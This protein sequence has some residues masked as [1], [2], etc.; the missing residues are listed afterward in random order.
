MTKASPTYSKRQKIWIALAA[1]LYPLLHYYNSNFDIADSPIQWA[2]LLGICIVFPLVSVFVFPLLLKWKPNAFLQKRYLACINLVVFFGLVAMLVFMPNDKTLAVVLVLAGLLGFVFYKFLWK[3]VILQ[4]LLA[5]MS[6][7]TLV[8]RIGFMMNYTEDWA[9]PADQIAQTDFVHTPNIYMIQPDGYV[10]FSWLDKAPYSHDDLSFKDWLSDQGFRHYP[11]FRSNYYSTVTSNSSMFAMRHHYYQNTYRGNLKTYGA[12]QVIVG[13]NTTLD[14]LK[15]NG[16]T[17]HLLTDNT[18]FL[19]NRKLKAFDHCNVPP[20]RM[21]MY[22][23]GGVYGIDIAAD[24]EAS[25]QAQGDEPQFYFIEKTIPAHIMYTEGPSL[26]AEGE[27]VTYL[28]RMATTDEWL[29]TLIGHIDRYDPGAMIVI[30]ADHGGFVG[31]D[32]YKEAEK[33]KLTETEA[34]SA[35]SSLLTIRW[36]PQTEANEIDIKSNVNLFRSMFSVLG[37]DPS[38]LSNR[39]DDGSFLPLMEGSNANYYQLLDAEGNFG[40]RL[41]EE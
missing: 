16:Y 37:E 39:E 18:F 13:A 17:T 5:V 25:L 38:L 14:G 8:P 20:H 26:G 28:E 15:H 31:L 2:F 7:V 35:F 21:S 29:R 34:W 22:D 11:E 9:A 41:L 1:G 10:N 23:T 33:R 12:Q 4:L 27:R 3:I 30:V 40:Y 6:A 32:Y 24:L 19:M 36:T